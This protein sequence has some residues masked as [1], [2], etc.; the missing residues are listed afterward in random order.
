MK[1]KKICLKNNITGANIMPI[2]PKEI[3]LILGVSGAGKTR[4]LGI[5]DEMSRIVRGE[6][7][8]LAGNEW[9]CEFEAGGRNFQWSGKFASKVQSEAEFDTWFKPRFEAEKLVCDGKD[10]I[11]RSG[12][13]I[14]FRDS[15]IPETRPDF[16]LLEIFSGIDEVRDA[17]IALNHIFYIGCNIEDFYIDDRIPED[18]FNGIDEQE[19]IKLPV[20]PMYKF[21]VALEKNFDIAK[22]IK[23][24]FISIFDSIEDVKITGSKVRFRYELFIKE[25][26]AGWVRSNSISAGM[27]KSLYLIAAVKLLPNE[28]V[29]LIDEFE[30]SL[31]ENCLSLITDI[32]NLNK[33]NMQFIITSHH[34]YV[35]NNIDISNWLVVMRN[36]N[37]VFVKSAED[38]KL[39][40][41]RHD[42][43]MQL[44]NSDAYL[45]GIN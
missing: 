18:S 24:D 17:R 16:S 5:I 12:N 31:G 35:I 21:A 4:Y 44:I 28:S 20:S 6:T 11:M 33:R 45:R 26:N 36:G 40:R 42:A 23:E 9:L 10:V 3:T 38:L 37:D 27:Y 14:I 39:G 30:N 25:K 29:V 43:F 22:E 2:Y 8:R 32:V 7:R 41:S 13:T 19:L 1:I 34:P 15:E